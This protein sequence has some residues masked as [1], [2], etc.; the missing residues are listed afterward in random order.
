MNDIAF[1][2]DED[3]GRLLAWRCNAAI[4]RGEFLKDV[5]ALARQ[6]PPAGHVLNHCEDRY[7]F[8]VGLAAALVRGQ[9]SLFPPSRAPQGLAELARE[10]PDLY[11]L[12]DQDD[13]AVPMAVQRFTR[14]ALAAAAVTE[15]PRR[16]AF[17]ASRVVALAFTSGSTG[18]PGRHPRSWGGFVREAEQAGECLGLDAARTGA[19]VATV[20]PQHMY[21][22]IASIMLPIRWGYMLDAGRPFYPEDIRRTLAACPCPAVLVTTPVQLRACVLDET[23]LPPL[24]FILSSTAPLA[25][26]TACAAEQRFAARVMEFYGSTETGAMAVR[27]QAEGE[28]WRTFADVR[29]SSDP[30]GLRVAAPYLPQSIVLAD[31]AEVHDAQSFTLHGRNADLVKIGGKRASLADLNR[32]LLEIDGVR[33]GT[34]FVPE[35]DGARE[36]RLTAFVVAPGLSRE[37]LLA[38]LRERIDPVFLPRPLHLVAGLP[39]NST[40]KLAR[41]SLQRLLEETGTTQA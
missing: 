31:R 2:P 34:F 10:F 37:R 38:A 3:L 12:T 22:F 29:V 4:T 17:A 35:A 28:R 26:E 27:R 24:D 15:E 41:A 40:G 8:L 25:A 19:I 36:P 7:H 14:E 23:R 6:L 33:D 16:P 18:K 21:G 11:C 13:E 39:R 20:P 9:L 1:F 30:S 5:G 32:R